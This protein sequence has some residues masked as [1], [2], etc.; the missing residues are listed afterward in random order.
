[1][2]VPYVRP[3]FLGCGR[4]YTPNFYH[5]TW[6]LQKMVYMGLRGFPELGVPLAVIHL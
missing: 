6:Y 5:L 2:E 4:G 1:M 3:M